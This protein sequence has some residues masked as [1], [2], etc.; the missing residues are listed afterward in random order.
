MIQLQ[1]ESCGKHMKA[2]REAAGK[3]AKCPACGHSVY[4]PTPP[5]EVDELPL[6]P[7]DPEELRREEALLDERRRLDRILSREERPPVEGGTG[8]R[9]TGNRE[10]GGG[11]VSRGPAPAPSS[12]SSSP[13]QAIEQAAVE[14]LV[15]MRDSDLE[16]AQNALAVLKRNR[17]EARQAVDRLLADQIP[18]APMSRV[19][20]PVYQGFLKSLRAQL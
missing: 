7:D 20:T 2:P 17:N 11:H 14:Y 1:C 16:R 18:P 9:P 13:T 8:T 3:A 10:A 15:A 6:A 5:E 4:I 12:A 19:P